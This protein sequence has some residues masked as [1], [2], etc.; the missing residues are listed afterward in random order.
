MGFELYVGCGS[1]SYPRGK[2]GE[3]TG[4]RGSWAVR[5][6]AG[7]DEKGGM[8]AHGRPREGMGLSVGCTELIFLVQPCFSSR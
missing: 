4:F 6:S 1:V 7:L 8:T 2:G 3:R 5:G